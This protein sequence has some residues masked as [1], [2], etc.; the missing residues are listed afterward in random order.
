M[1]ASSL[2]NAAVPPSGHLPAVTLG[3]LLDFLA[4]YDIAVQPPNSRRTFRWFNA[5]LRG[6]VSKPTGLRSG[7][8]LN[9][10]RIGE[11]RNILE[12]D[13]NAFACALSSDGA[14]PNN[15][16]LYEERLV[17][18]RQKDTFSYFLI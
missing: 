5:S 14:V 12:E 9:I 15:L 16:G 13:E 7:Q 10:C 3:M 8:V 6:T 11:V 4:D 18:I 17:V 2:F 1:C